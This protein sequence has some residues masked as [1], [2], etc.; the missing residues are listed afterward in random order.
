VRFRIR[1][2]EGDAAHR[3]RDDIRPALIRRPDARIFV[4]RNASSLL[5][6]VTSFRRFVAWLASLARRTVRRTANMSAKENGLF[7]GAHNV[8]GRSDQPG[9]SAERSFN[10]WPI[11][12]AVRYG[13]RINKYPRGWNVSASASLCSAFRPSVSRSMRK[14]DRAFLT[15]RKPE[16]IARSIR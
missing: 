3:P 4:V 2:V 15:R 10:T 16:P 9:K 5:G 7:G 1:R 12:P 8:V 11:A 14:P 6:A 13:F